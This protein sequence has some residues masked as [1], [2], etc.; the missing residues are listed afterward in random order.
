MPGAIR[1]QGIG[2]VVGVPGDHHI[3]P[4]IQL[5]HDAQ[6]RSMPRE[7]IA[8]GHRHHAL[9]NGHEDGVDALRLQLPGRLR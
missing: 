5:R 2:E 7:P 9:M 8:R 6:Q 1:P 3:D 4:R